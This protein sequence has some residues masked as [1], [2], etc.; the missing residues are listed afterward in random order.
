MAAASS[1]RARRDIRQ[2]LQG[3]ER[4]I[5]RTQPFR[6]DLPAAVAAANAAG[7][8]VDVTAEWALYPG[9][10]TLVTALDAYRAP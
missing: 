4:A 3:V 10:Q 1:K 5:S 8:G 2:L 7:A 9:L 6:K